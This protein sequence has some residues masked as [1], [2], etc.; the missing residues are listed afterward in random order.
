M[1]AAISASRPSP[2]Y[3]SP[4]Y[5]SSPYRS[6]PVLMSHHPVLVQPGA[7]GADRRVQ[8]AL[9]RALGNAQ[10]LGDVPYRQIGVEAQH[11]HL[12]LGGREFVQALPEGEGEQTGL[13]AGRG[14]RSGQRGQPLPQPF[15][16]LPGPVPVQREPGGDHRRPRRH[17][18]RR[19]LPARGA[20]QQPQPHLLHPVRQL[21]LRHPAE[22]QHRPHPPLLHGVQRIVAAAARGRRTAAAPVRPSPPHGPP[23]PLPPYD[24]PTTPRRAETFGPARAAGRGV[25]HIVV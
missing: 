3:R 15:L 20:L 10:G 13:L 24:A 25:R 21:R 17:V 9:D 19:L 7:Q 18:P 23:P 11:E 1:I 5:R 22:R 12:A 4:S 8:P 6:S 14:R 2:P 16:P